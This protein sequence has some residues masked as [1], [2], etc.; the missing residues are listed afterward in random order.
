MR[1][2]KTLVLFLFALLLCSPPVSALGNGGTVRSDSTEVTPKPLR[3]PDDPNGGGFGDDDQDNP[4]T[5]DSGGTFGDNDQSNPSTEG[6]GGGFSDSDMGGGVPLGDE[7]D[8]PIIVFADEVVKALCV[9]NWDVNGD[10]ELSENEAAVVT[11]LSIVFQGNEDITSFEE[12][13]YFIGLTTIRASA[14]DGCSN[15]TVINVPN[16]VT[17]IGNEA[18]LGCFGLTSMDIPNGVTSIGEGTFKYCNGLISVSLPASVTSIGNA[19]FSGCSGLSQVKADMLEPP[20]ISSNTF[21]NRR[22]ATLIVPSG[23]VAAYAAADYWKEFNIVEDVGIVPGDANNDGSVTIS[24][25]VAI[26]SYIL[27]NGNPTGT[28]VFKAANMDDDEVI[29]IADAIAIVNIILS[30]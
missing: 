26:V 22:N 2:Y 30:E 24:D 10:G 15:L 25:A 21:T 17:S 19:A 14:F 12:L 29:T 27:T 6:G 18:F 28:F 8:S 9:D 20:A 1:A 16:H 7:D 23:C 4:S 3:G 11:D 5:G 13:S